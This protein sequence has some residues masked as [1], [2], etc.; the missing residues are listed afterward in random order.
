MTLKER[1]NRDKRE[2][3]RARCKFIAAEMRIKNGELLPN[4]ELVELFELMLAR[5]EYLYLDVQKLTHYID[6]DIL[7]EDIGV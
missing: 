4:Q 1:I 2:Y 5:A 6:H 3:N 7:N